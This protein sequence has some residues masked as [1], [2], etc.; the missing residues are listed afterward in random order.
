MEEEASVVLAFWD[1]EEESDQAAAPGE[2]RAMARRAGEAMQRAMTTGKDRV[3][4][5]TPRGRLIAGTALL[6]IAAGL[7]LGFHFRRR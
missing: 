3:S 7:A 5:L 2:P 4:N 6:G 1:G